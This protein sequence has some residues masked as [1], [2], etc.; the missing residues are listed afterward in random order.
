MWNKVPCH[1]TTLKKNS[2]IFFPD[3]GITNSIFFHNMLWQNYMLW[4]FGFY[5]SVLSKTKFDVIHHD[6][7]VHTL[8][9]YKIHWCMHW[10]KFELKASWRH[11]KVLTTKIVQNFINKEKKLSYYVWHGIVLEIQTFK[12]VF[13]LKIY[14]NVTNENM[15]LKLI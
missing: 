12:Y 6:V 3:Y 7:H 15:I 11:T 10:S 4:F 2:S 13:F 9:V 8:H 5:F 14:S 1:H